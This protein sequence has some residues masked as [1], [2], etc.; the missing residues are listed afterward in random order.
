MRSKRGRIYAQFV[1]RIL[2]IVIIP[3]FLMAI[4]YYHNLRTFSDEVY[5]K[6]V[7]ILENNAAGIENMV[8]AVNNI[9]YYVDNNTLVRDFLNYRSLNE[10]GT[11]TNSV[12][13]L[14]K[15]IASL[16]VAN[17]TIINIQIYSR[18]NDMLIDR[19]TAAVNIDRYYGRAFYFGDT[20]Y[21][22][23]KNEFL[24]REHMGNPCYVPVQVFSENK[25]QDALLFG[26]NLPL[27]TGNYSRGSIS[28]LLD[29]EKL[30]NNF[31]NTG[32]QNGGYL[33]IQ[34]DGGTVLCQDNRTG[35][36]NSFPAGKQEL[37]KGE[38]GYFTD[39]IQN[40]KF[41]ITYYQ[42]KNGWNYLLAVP[43]NMIMRDVNRNLMFLI[44]VLVIALMAGGIL[45]HSYTAWVS[46]PIQSVCSKLYKENER[47]SYNDFGEKIEEMIRENEGMQ[48]EMKRLVPAL[49]TSVFHSLLSGNYQSAD[50]IRMSLEKLN[51]PIDKNSRYI[52]MIA[53]MN[54]LDTDTGLEKIAAQ[55][56]YMRDLLGRILGT[57]QIYDLNF[58][59]IG[60]LIVVPMETHKKIKADCEQK[61]EMLN[62]EQKK[63]LDISVSFHGNILDNPEEIPMAFKNI[64]RMLLVE[65]GFAN[66]TIQWYEKNEKQEGF[67][68]PVEIEEKLLDSILWGNECDTALIL[69]KIGRHNRRTL[70]NPDPADALA[71]ISAMLNS[72]KR[73][74]DTV[75]I[76]DVL[77]QKKAIERGCAEGM[78]SRECFLLLEKLFLQLCHIQKS[79][80]EQNTL[81][82]ELKVKRFVEKNYTDPQLSLS[83][84]A[85]R[86]QISEVYLSKLFKQ[87]FGQNFSKYVESLR[88]NEAARLL[89][90]GNM[91]IAQIAERVGYNSPQSFRR[92]YKRVFGTTPRE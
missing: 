5:E 61:I 90:D 78:A 34:D 29:R 71:L 35:N 69:D 80:L 4:A 60:I 76:E 3:V 16:V 65:Y 14:Q 44:L 28:I 81:D 49:Q 56:V 30:I 41:I 18:K 58:S 11:N 86:F 19:G 31:K 68:Y 74:E 7:S 37:M 64:G 9:L 63:H 87:S 53:S 33:Y 24:L 8:D 36:P 13:Q 84:V 22:T 2:P 23:W 32:Y 70:D 52:V 48:E 66:R 21:K 83:M 43:Q 59:E 45:M 39:T 73:I 89:E 88:L 91:S 67:Y 40:H 51:V 10:D 6:N 26:S 77:E 27:N 17:D 20:D 1:I 75:V 47:I 62:E 54:D 25:Q 42:D 15:E 46:E 38:K 72:V 57:E 50:E 79:N 12:L 82:L 92:A 55:K 85:S